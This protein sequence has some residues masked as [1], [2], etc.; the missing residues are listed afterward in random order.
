MIKFKMQKQNDKTEQQIQTCIT[1]KKL[2]KRATAS[3]NNCITSPPPPP[4]PSLPRIHP[5][6]VY[7]F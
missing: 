3:I 1:Y 7:Q 2:Y 4:P 6:H 5:K